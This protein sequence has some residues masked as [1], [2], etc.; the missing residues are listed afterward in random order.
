MVSCSLRDAR[1][2]GI[3][4]ATEIEPPEE[5]AEVQEKGER[6]KKRTEIG[7]SAVQLSL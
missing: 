2:E 1:Y 6:N 3:I 7:M 5:G 4:D